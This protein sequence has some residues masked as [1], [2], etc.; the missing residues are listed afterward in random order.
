MDNKPIYMTLSHLNTEEGINTFFS[1]KWFLGVFVPNEESNV[2]FDR[3]EY[4][5][6]IENITYN[7]KKVNKFPYFIRVPKRFQDEV[8]KGMVRFKCVV[9]ASKSIETGRWWLTFKEFVNPNNGAFQ[10]ISKT[11]I[12]RPTTIQ[13]KAT[14]DEKDMM[15]KLK[16]QNDRFGQF[17]KYPFRLI[18]D[19]T[20][21]VDGSFTIRDIRRPDFSK[22][23]MPNGESQSVIIFHPK[24]LRPVDGKY[25]EFSWVLTK[26]H[27][28]FKFSF[29]VDESAPLTEITP[30]ELIK[31][32]NKDISNYPASASQKIVR[33]LDTLKNQLTASG[34]EIFIYELL[35][36]ADDYP[37][38]DEGVKVRFYIT[39][40]YLLFEHSGAVFNERNIAALCSINDKEKTENKETIGYKGIG[41][42]TVFLDNNFV[43]LQ[44]GPF[45]FKYSEEDTKDVVDTPWQILPIGT[46][47]DFSTEISNVFQK[48]GDEFRVRFAL[49]PIKHDTLRDST[50]NYVE[51][52]NRVFENERVILFLRHV[53]SVE[54]YYSNSETPDIT[55]K[56]S[57]E[58]WEVD[59]YPSDVPSDVY[60]QINADIDKQEELGTLK[61]PTKYYNFT[62]TV[63][64]FACKREG[65]SLKAVDDANIYCYLP[66]KAKFGFD[67]LLNTDM[68]PNGARDNVLTEFDNQ[69]NVNEE[70]AA[71]AGNKFFQWI[72]NLC[73][74][75][76]FKLDSIFSLIP[77]F[78]TCIN[79]HG[80]YKN[81]IS[82]FQNAFEARLQSEP[83]IPTDKENPSLL[84]DTIFDETGI[85]VS[86]CLTDEEFLKFTQLMGNLPAKILR[87]SRDFKDFQRRYLKKFDRT[88][89]I[90][91]MQDLLDLCDNSDFQ[92][93][94][95][96]NTHNQN[97]LDFIIKNASNDELKSFT[98]KKI[99]L[100]QKGELFS[101]KELVYDYENYVNALGVF[102]SYFNYLQPSTKKNLVDNTT[103]QSF[104][105][106][107]GNLFATFD[108]DRFVNQ[109]LLSEENTH[110]VTSSLKVMAD[111]NIFYSFLRQYNISCNDS[112]RR[113][114]FFD[115]NNVLVNNFLSGLI[116]FESTEGEN[117]KTETWLDTN[118]IHFVSPKYSEDAIS[119]F[120]INIG[121]GD[122]SHEIVISRLI[123]SDPILKLDRNYS[124]DIKVKIQENP[125]NNIDFVS[126]CY[127]HRDAIP[128]KFLS[129]YPLY[130]ANKKTNGYVEEV[131][132]EPEIDNQT[133]NAFS[134]ESAIINYTNYILPEDH[135][136]F[137]SKL[138]DQLFK[139]TWVGKEWMY[140]LSTDYFKEKTE[141]EIKALKKFFK[142]K[143]G[144]NELNNNN[145]YDEIISA[146]IEEVK[147]N[148][149]ADKEANYDFVSFLDDNFKHIFEDNLNSVK[150]YETMPIVDNKDEIIKVKIKDT[151]KIDE[152][153]DGVSSYLSSYLY[154]TK[155]EGL[156]NLPWM[157]NNPIF[158]AN[159]EYG[160]SPSLKA[161]GVKTYNFTD[162]FAHVIATS[163]LTYILS[164]FKDFDDN[165]AFHDML[166]KEVTDLSQFATIREKVPVYLL[167]HEM[168]APKSTGHQILSKAA[169]ELFDLNLV[170][171]KELD[172]IDS[173]YNTE[174]SQS[175]WKDDDRLANKQ[176][177]INHFV[178]WLK[179][180]TN[181]LISKLSEEDANIKF[182]RWAKDRIGDNYSVLQ[183]LPV[184][185]KDPQGENTTSKTALLSSTIYMCDK[186]M[187]NESYEELVQSYLENATVI[188]DKYYVENDDPKSWKEF[189]SKLNVKCDEVG[190]LVSTLKDLGDRNIDKLFK[191]L[192]H[193]RKELEKVEPNL[194]A[195]LT[196]I[197][198]KST[199]GNWYAAKD[200]IYID[201]EKEEPLKMVSLPNVVSFET[202]DEKVLMNDIIKLKVGKK[203]TTLTEWIGLKIGHYLALQSADIEKI[204]PIHF[205][206]IG[207]LT[208]L[209]NNDNTALE[210]FS[211]DIS[212]IKLQTRNGGYLQAKQITA[213]AAY[214][215]YCNFEA[216]HLN[217]EYLSD[218]YLTKS[219]KSQ[220][221]LFKYFALHHDLWTTDLVNLKDNKEFA[222]YIW[223]EYLSGTNSLVTV[224]H[225]VNMIRND[226][227][228]GIECIPTKHGVKRAEDLYSPR[229]EPYVRKLS[230]NNNIQNHQN[231]EDLVPCIKSK[232]IDKDNDKTV[233]DLLPFKSQLSFND[234]ILSLFCL[235]SPENRGQI[236]RWMISPLPG[237]IEENARLKKINAYR[238]DENAQW[239]N[240]LRKYV[241][242]K[243]LYALDADSKALTQYFG[244]S[245]VV[246]SNLYFMSNGVID[247]SLMAKACNVLGITIIKGDEVAITPKELPVQD[248]KK[249]NRFFCMIALL[250]ASIEQEDSWKELYEKYCRKINQMNMI[251]C[252]SISIVYTSNPSIS[253]DKQKFY[254]E[255]KDEVNFYYVDDIKDKSFYGFKNPLVL[256][257]FAEAFKDYIS[258]EF[259]KDML[260]ELLIYPQY[261]LK[262]KFVEQINILH[263][264][265]FLNAAAEYFPE[266]LNIKQDEDAPD[267]LGPSSYGPE[268]SE[269]DAT[270]STNR[271]EPTI[272]EP[273]EPDYGESYPEDD[274]PEGSEEE[275]EEDGKDN[276]SGHSS[277]NRPNQPNGTST[278]MHQR[279]GQLN[280]NEHRPQRHG[281]EN[282]S[283]GHSTTSK[284][285]VYSAEEIAKWKSSG[286]PFEVST[287]EANEEERGEISALL[288]EDF[289]AEQV[290][291]ANYLA[292]LRL[293]KSLRDAGHV[294]DNDDEEAFVRDG[295]KKDEIKLANGKWIHKCSAAHGILYISPKVWNMVSNDRYIVC[296]YVG[297]KQD[298]FFYLRSKDD[299]LKLIGNDNIIIKMTG[300]ERVKAV[301]ELYQNVLNNVTGSAYTMIR[302]KSNEEY[303]S[304]FEPI[305]NNGTDN[306]DDL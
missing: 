66:T 22:L 122:F 74:K 215:P 14:E 97:F 305:M 155:L 37:N 282:H 94:L 106:K 38:G 192:A 140:C 290:A 6:V 169:K 150:N 293:F 68:I 121:I 165:K 50:Q 265:E 218:D 17:T 247:T 59:K 224:S 69:I 153:E 264:D 31:R 188:S 302:V 243:N 289:T 256:S 220:R 166:Q 109:V 206:F 136:F 271:N 286:K 127:E 142:D 129:S 20:Q 203:I 3:S 185:V 297:A 90:W 54:V 63:V 252:S 240:V 83:L 62:K 128:D 266:L 44:T 163:N 277:A 196:K 262:A 49:R 193:N 7:G 284:P 105:E 294:T 87:R 101:A 291:D 159:K 209:Y 183:G 261:I 125:N 174:S 234:C 111:S 82:R 295:A 75:K 56:K 131:S 98:A 112:I 41:F 84:T 85:T 199:T 296:V 173:R 274:T 200:V 73:E 204:K 303:N 25:Y 104:L 124:N 57:N 133:L 108:P 126:Y 235:T 214:K 238:E 233:F 99:F 72:Y 132:Q 158:M 48:S 93:W 67:F 30:K 79:E 228:K 292:Q 244:N 236:L 103:W 219:E 287:R 257:D 211:E 178:A 70:L 221:F 149:G 45:S 190:I 28:D 288:G 213:G 216:F 269:P 61:I 157:G 27:E 23:I 4:C 246:I 170:D 81:L 102:A 144:V 268:D 154:D 164:T 202:S 123:A 92:E 241:Q 273:Q 16:L 13:R 198:L 260:K 270:D 10:P 304:F 285:H 306:V 143:Y 24:E 299:I 113:L 11:P 197:N 18:G 201:C 186:Y 279:N 162:F 181:Q 250:I 254:H 251:E 35:Q 36:N 207:E 5:G 168:P 96:D 189:W 89:N 280:S 55:R 152:D 242:V 180:H 225:I 208:K 161:I 9:N 110:S 86:G 281:T 135:I 120:R 171:E 283:N 26:V 15:R 184:L 255:N 118:W 119:Y 172:I 2:T 138:Y 115:A 227:F 116:F 230:E 77:V 1:R 151:S 130:T 258:T 176:F 141:D 76:E 60:N 226:A 205:K 39:E 95:K 145:F 117:I 137:S 134:K 263:D 160:D 46:R 223:S 65:A 175:Y 80:D 278:G 194:V 275:Q 276:A 33:M 64:S 248:I 217:Y 210:S 47:P 298:D 146:H 139:K 34:K 53:E 114:P 182:W 148:I 19:F 253:R 71:I 259:D 237:D 88:E 232:K 231:Y 239:M 78:T 249:F 8:H 21:N 187:E 100:N 156:M 52:F 29:K 272:E 40:N 12:K 107:N 229:I 212:Q 195:K 245:P 51:M 191:S 267:E 32:L 167:G 222:V 177:T 301:D 43:Y 91:Q 300:Q 58:N 147:A 179:G 42:K